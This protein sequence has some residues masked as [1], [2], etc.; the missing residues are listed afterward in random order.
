VVKLAIDI[1]YSSRKN[2]Y[3]GLSIGVLL[4]ILAVAV[5]SLVEGSPFGL[6]ILTPGGASYSY[7]LS[8]IPWLLV[9]L[10]VIARRLLRQ[11]VADDSSIKESETSIPG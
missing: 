5:V 9:A 4:A 11:P 1:I 8:P 3:Y 2:R 6:G 10:L 7:I